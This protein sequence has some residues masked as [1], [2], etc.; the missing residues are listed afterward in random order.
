M[1]VSK[2]HRVRDV[3]EECPHCYTFDVEGHLEDNGGDDI[4]REMGC[5]NCYATWSIPYAACQWESI[6]E[7][8]N[9]IPD[10]YRHVVHLRT[11]KYFDTSPGGN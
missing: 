9:P 2:G 5:N 7:P 8:I 1:T 11:T 6:E 10:P 3:S 4:H